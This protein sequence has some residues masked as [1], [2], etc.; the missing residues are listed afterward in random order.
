MPG[1]SMPTIRRSRSTASR[2]AGA[3]TCTEL[4][5]FGVPAV[6]VPLPIAT[7]DHQAANAGV[8]VAAGGAVLVRQD[9]LTRVPDLVDELLRDDRRLR[10]MSEA[11]RALARPQAADE[12]ANE[13]VVLAEGRA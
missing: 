8:L 5:A 13:L 11:M 6:M 12:I 3:G 4:A 1:R 10:A 7:R 9:E 2:R